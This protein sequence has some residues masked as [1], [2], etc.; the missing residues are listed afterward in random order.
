MAAKPTEDMTIGEMLVKIGSGLHEI[1]RYYAANYGLVNRNPEYPRLPKNTPLYINC[2]PYSI[3]RTEKEGEEDLVRLAHEVPYEGSWFYTPKD[4]TWYHFSEGHEE[5]FGQ[6]GL[7]RLSSI[8]RGGSLNI[9][10]EEIVHYHTHPKRAGE[11]FVLWAG[12]EVERNMA[13]VDASVVNKFMAACMYLYSAFPSDSDVE[14][15]REWSQQP[16]SFQGKIASPIGIT[17]VEIVDQD[18]DIVKEYHTLH[19]NL[20]NLL[21]DYVRLESGGIT[22]SAEDMFDCVNAKIQGRLQLTFQQING[23]ITL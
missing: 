13:G 23:G 3:K 12:T 9:P 7:F 17:K 5:E 21:K 6:N 22:L 4:S 10:G 15:Y 11:H 2:K 1:G 8:Q 14:M 20:M 18:E 16:V 19:K